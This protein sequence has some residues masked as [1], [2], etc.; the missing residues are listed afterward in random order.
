MFS[1]NVK[2]TNI[3][4][5]NTTSGVDLKRSLTTKK[6]FCF[7]LKEITKFGR[8]ETHCRSKTFSIAVF[9]CIE[10]CSGAENKVNN[11]IDFDQMN[12]CPSK[13]PAL[14]SNFKMSKTKLGLIFNII[15][16]M[17]DHCD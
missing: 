3:R 6:M 17:A 4:L 11:T 13:C 7:S 15:D 2:Y 10:F 12:Y 5:Q 16:P 8:S 9:R 1:Q 14:G